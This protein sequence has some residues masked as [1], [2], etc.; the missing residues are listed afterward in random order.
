MFAADKS[1]LG[2]LVTSPFTI[3]ATAATTLNEHAKQATH[4]KAVASMA[5]AEYRFKHCAPSI[6]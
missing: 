3:F 5:E 6:N 4:L 2:Q 1:L